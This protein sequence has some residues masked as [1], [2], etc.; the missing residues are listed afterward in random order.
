M[1]KEIFMPY[2]QTPSMSIVG[3]AAESI[4]KQTKLRKGSL[5]RRPLN[6]P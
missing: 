1:V 5:G 2:R 4:C 3:S 6:I